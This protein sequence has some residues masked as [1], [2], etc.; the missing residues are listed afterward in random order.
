MHSYLMTMHMKNKNNFSH[1]FSM[2][3]GKIYV[4]NLKRYIIRIRQGRGVS[5]WLPKAGGGA[6]TL[7]FQ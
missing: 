3:I 4:K 6:K 7:N 1:F 2:E 5:K